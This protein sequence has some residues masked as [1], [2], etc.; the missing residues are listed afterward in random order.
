MVE[1]PTRKKNRIHGKLLV[2][3]PV[4]AVGPGEVSGAVKRY[5]HAC[6]YHRFMMATKLEGGARQVVEQVVGRMIRTDGFEG[7]REGWCCADNLWW[8]RKDRMGEASSY[9]VMD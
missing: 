6:S 3:V 7:G 9:R 4:T 2:P 8:E 1:I 5:N